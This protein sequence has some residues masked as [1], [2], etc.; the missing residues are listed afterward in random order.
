MKTISRKSN[1]HS[2]HTTLMIVVLIF[3]II[4]VSGQMTGN[5]NIIDKELS[6][7]IVDSI[8]SCFVNNY[9]YPEKADEIRRLLILNSTEGKYNSCKDIEKLIEM[10]QNDMYEITKDHHI[11]ISYIQS[12]LSAKKKNEKSLLT[13]KDKQL[14]RK[15]YHFP[16]IEIMPGNIGYIRLDRFTGSDNA[17]ITAKSAMQFLSNSDAIIIDLRYNPGG[18]GPLLP[19][20]AGYFVDEPTLLGDL[21]FP[22]NDSLVQSWTYATFE[23]K[24]TNVPLYILTSF[25]TASA[26]ESFTSF[27]KF[28]NRAIIVGETTKGASHWC[29]YYYYPQHSFEIKLPIARPLNHD[30]ENTGISPDIEIVEHMALDKAYLVA[31]EKLRSNC[32][33]E[34]YVTDYNWYHK[35]TSMRMQSNFEK[36]K[37]VEKYAGTYENNQLIIYKENTLFW[38]QNDNEIFPLIPFTDDTFLFSD[39]EDYMLEFVRNEDGIIAGYQL[40]T[41]YTTNPVLRKKISY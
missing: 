25:Q 8:T 38:Y 2:W 14:A 6:E 12:K 15:N 41:A 39:S 20:I 27:F 37:E 7:A 22:G 29:N 34:R 16:I 35:V 28:Q 9:V 23:K 33:D 31:L 21:Y 24:L 11:G 18:G 1:S 3:T 5:K 4:R 17:I 10:L 32:A 36:G 13:A 30:W 26:A 19:L 40:I